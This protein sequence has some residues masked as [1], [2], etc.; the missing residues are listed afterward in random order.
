MEDSI[1]V[2]S[3]ILFEQI[4]AKLNEFKDSIK[5]PFYLDNKLLS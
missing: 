2:E 4:D 1:T 5:N 3:S